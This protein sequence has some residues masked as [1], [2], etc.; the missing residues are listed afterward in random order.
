VQSG[1]GTSN[2]YYE[3]VVVTTNKIAFL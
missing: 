3:L 2:S 1:T